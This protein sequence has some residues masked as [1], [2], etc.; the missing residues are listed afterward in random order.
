ML[1]IVGDRLHPCLL[2]AISTLEKSID[3]KSGWLAI[4]KNLEEN[5]EYCS[6][7]PLRS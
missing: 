1:V 5:E 6:P 2:E 7:A 4:I 3:I